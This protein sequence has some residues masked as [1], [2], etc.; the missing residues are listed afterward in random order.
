MGTGASFIED[1]SNP[2]FYRNVQ[3]TDTAL[4]INPECPYSYGCTV[5]GSSNAGRTQAE[6]EDLVGIDGVRH[7]VA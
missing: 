1:R 3:K 4:N 6:S 7:R 2:L 5:W